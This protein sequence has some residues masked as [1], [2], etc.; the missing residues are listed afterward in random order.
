MSTS[1]SPGPGVRRPTGPESPADETETLTE[2]G[3]RAGTIPYMSPEQ[4]RGDESD[5]RTD[6]FA[7]GLIVYEMTTGRHPFRRGTPAETL[8]AIINEDLPPTPAPDGRAPLQ[9][10]WITERCLAKAPDDRYGTTADVYRDLRTLRDRLGEVVSQNAGLLAPA[11]GGMRR[12]ALVAGSLVAALALGAGSMWFTLEPWLADRSELRFT[13]FATAPALETFPAWSPDGQ[14]IAYVAE[15]EGILQI[16]TR[17]VSSPSSAQITSRPYD[18]KYPFWSHDGKRIYYVSL[19]ADREGIWSVGATGGTPQVVVRNAS[20]GAISADGRLAFLRAEDRAEIVP[21][22]SLF[23]A[24]P[25]GEPPWTPEAV[26]A[27]AEKY[28]PLQSM[29]FVEGALAFAPDGTKLGVMAVGSFAN[30]SDADLGWQFWTA[31]LA[32]G[33]AQRRLQSWP[34]VVPVVTSFAWLPDSRHVVLGVT[35]IDPAR[36]HLYTADLET[37]HA[38]PLTHSADSEFHPSTSP[39]GE[40]VVFVRGEPDY[41]L[42]EFSVTGSSATTLL[43]TARNE[44]DP[45]WF[46]DGRSF[47]YVTDRRGK[48]EIWQ[49]ARDGSIDQPLVTQELFGSDLTI[50]LTEPAVSPDGQRVAYLRN[51]Y[52]PIWPL[53]IWISYVAGGTA[54][55]LL[56]RS[57]GG[58][59]GAPSWSPDGQWIAYSEYKDRQV[60]LV[61]VR[62]GTEERIVLRRDGVPNANARWSPRNDWITWETENGF[63]LVSPDGTKDRHLYDGQFLVHA[64]SPERPEVIGIEETEDLRLVLKA[65]D[66]G[67]GRVRMLREIGP[68]PPVNQQVRGL[69]LGVDGRTIATS[70]VTLRGD[71]WLLRDLPWQEWSSRWRWAF[72]RPPMKTP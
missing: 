16:H 43:S 4:A 64:W 47:A 52:V 60:M 12:R 23:M 70:T 19:A 46:P 72:R 31:P 1:V 61:K 62:V 51:G 22:A 32:G 24:R 69:S 71:L 8:H 49:R 28:A 34:N 67:T 17:G 58:L 37:D 5:F 26:D 21:S 57:Q 18:C 3:L 13:P 63:S 42:T 9:L 50:L 39:G 15:V 11:R 56:P 7:F 45:A 14:T 20:R 65:I 36:T 25:A 66:A 53:R 48:P 6:Q 29:R 38:W 27:A 68:S 59:Q 44:S 55:P 10:S 54:T 2:L 33:P 35:A 40:S 41:D 30:P